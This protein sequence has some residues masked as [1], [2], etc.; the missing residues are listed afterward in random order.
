M[1]HNY[2]GQEELRYP[3]SY[4]NPQQQQ[5]S[6]PS[7]YQ[8]HP[9]EN[10]YGNPVHTAEQQY[11]VDFNGD[12]DLDMILG[13]LNENSPTTVRR[14]GQAAAAAAADGTLSNPNVSPD[15]ASGVPSGQFYSSAYPGSAGGHSSTNVVGSL[16]R[17]AGYRDPGDPSVDSIRKA[18]LMGTLPSDDAGPGTS[19]QWMENNR[20]S[21]FY[22]ADFGPTPAS[23]GFDTQDPPAGPHMRQQPPAVRE[24]SNAPLNQH[25]HDPSGNPRNG[26]PPLSMR[27]TQMGGLPTPAYSADTYGPPLHMQQREPEHVPYSS[28]MGYGYPP[29]YSRPIA[30]PNTRRKACEPCRR[31]KLR[32]DGN[33]PECSTCAA[34]TQ[35]R[36]CVYASVVPT[37]GDPFA[38]AQDSEEIMLKRRLADMQGLAERVEALEASLAAARNKNH[39]SGNEDCM[40]GSVSPNSLTSNINNGADGATPLQIQSMSEEEAYQSP[41][42]V[43]V[44]DRE[45][46]AW[47]GQFIH[48]FDQLCV[49]P[50]TEEQLESVSSLAP[51][52]QLDMLPDPQELYINNDLLDLYFR[53]SSCMIPYPVI[54]PGT[55]R[56]N[57][58][59]TPPML[60]YA[61]YANT[62]PYSTDTKTRN[63]VNAFYR[64]ARSLILANLENP[65]IVV[66]QC[67]HL[68]S[69]ASIIKGSLDTAWT[70]MSMAC[71][72]AHYLHLDQDPEELGYTD[73]VEIETRRRLWWAIYV[74]DAIRSSAQMRSSYF[75]RRKAYT[76]KSPCSEGRWEFSDSAGNLP[77][78]L[79]GIKDHNYIASWTSFAPIYAKAVTYNYSALATGVDLTV[80]DDRAMSLI[81]E[82]EH[83]YRRCPPTVQSVPFANSFTTNPL[84]STSAIPYHAVNIYFSKIATI[85]AIQ[86]PR[87][88]AAL[89]N[90]FKDP[91]AADTIE[92][93]KRAAEAVAHLAGRLLDAP[94]P[95]ERD[96]GITCHAQHVSIIPSM[97]ILEA[98]FIL[99]M[100]SAYEASKRN[101]V[102]FETAQKGLSDI[103]RM[104]RA[105][106]RPYSPQL[107]MAHVLAKVNERILA[108]LKGKKRLNE[109]EGAGTGARPTFVI[110][111]ASAQRQQ[112]I[113]LGAEMERGLPVPVMN[114]RKNVAAGG[115]EGASVGSH[116]QQGLRGPTYPPQVDARQYGLHQYH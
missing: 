84:S 25:Q 3:L 78:H 21:G 6:N 49:D 10:R 28:T 41:S 32:C 19:Q 71:R 31:K 69:T 5:Q 116:H 39:Q 44:E 104:L 114:G 94:N 45:A 75:Q 91:Q 57:M 12:V 14:A 96:E 67:L 43:L 9:A 48:Q 113:G 22:G 107:A 27:N 88:I 73:W 81:G 92:T 62:C 38:D 46:K 16:L 23:L 68:L 24:R 76:V 79:Q 56:K 1:S 87:L 111:D 80:Y 33:R 110:A 47:L 26:L 34:S 30:K 90:N 13:L 7:A 102:E 109:N 61:I 36:T 95:S 97:G 58:A 89:T 18:V 101:R 42:I 103:V 64:R 98:G 99:I 112:K 60:L 4:G 108:Q 8:Y 40:S 93:A 66:L 11:D 53:Y 100:M 83:W 54:H 55:L 20:D 65:S 17:E 15:A 105:F 70:L 59:N 72:M 82:I 86:R 115:W 85:C 50:Q 77:I 63:T 37:K 51:R 106:G 29:N 52:P 2:P 35:G 74:M